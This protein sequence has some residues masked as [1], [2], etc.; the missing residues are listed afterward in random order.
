MK[1]E[2]GIIKKIMSDPVLIV[3]WVL[4]FISVFFTRPDKE[5]LSYIDWRSLGI[6]WGLMVVIQ[7]LKEN[8]VFDIIGNYLLVRVKKGWQLAAIFIFLCFFGGM[9]ITNDVALI[10]FV[11]FAIMILESCGMK[12]M[13]LRVIV[14]QTIAANLG[15]MLTPI[16]NPQNLYLYGLTGMPIDEFIIW[17]LPYTILA[18]VLLIAGIAFLPGRNKG[19][20]VDNK[21]GDISKQHVKSGNIIIYLILFVLA[22]LTVLRIVTWYVMALIILAVVFVLDKKIILRADYMLLM[23]FIGFFIFTGNMGRVGYI[24]DMLERLVRGKEVYTSVIASQFIS[25][26]PATLLLSGFTDNH[27]AL[28]LG[29][30]LGGLGTLI[31]SMA[32]LISY[33]AFANEYKKEK[34]RYI[35]LFTVYNVLFLIALLGL[36]V[37]LN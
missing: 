7:G 12:K 22:V 36:Y 2:N 25:N 26:V 21:S 1:N 16:G 20:N 37:I 6:L 17:M 15:S 23:T 3:A 35:R 5:Y 8:S 29:V 19:I 33:K 28:L 13:A 4:A 10:T 11:P 32:S 34:G 14:L 31:A 24:R 18:L 27:K 30:N 9:L